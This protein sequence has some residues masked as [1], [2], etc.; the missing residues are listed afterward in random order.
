[1]NSYS[2]AIRK[3]HEALATEKRL[4]RIHLEWRRRIAKLRAV[5]CGWCK[6]WQPPS[7]PGSDRTEDEELALWNTGQEMPSGWCTR[8]QAPRDSDDHCLD[9]EEEEHDL[10]D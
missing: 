10:C 1:M 7:Y 4:E 6:Y 3:I 8:V 2:E 9:D 5:E